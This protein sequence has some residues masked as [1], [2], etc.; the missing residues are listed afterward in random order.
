MDDYI[1]GRGL[2]KLNDWI[3]YKRSDGV[4]IICFEL[5]AFPTAI[6][7]QIDVIYFSLH[8]WRNRTKLNGK[9]GEFSESS[10]GSKGMMMHI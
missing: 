10:S 9:K 6:C 8:F 4:I 3:G 1:F 5:N 2:T 7:T